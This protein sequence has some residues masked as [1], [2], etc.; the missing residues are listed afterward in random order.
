MKQKWAKELFGTEKWIVAMC[1]LDA[2]PGDPG[3]DSEGGF[4]KVVD[5]AR[6]DLNALQE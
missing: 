2:L 1:H 6:K 3:F 5:H 4:E